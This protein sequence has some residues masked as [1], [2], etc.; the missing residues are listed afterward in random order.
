MVTVESTGKQLSLKDYFALKENASKAFALMNFSEFMSFCQLGQQLCTKS[1]KPV[2]VAN[3]VFFAEIS[4]IAV[5]VYNRWHRR[6]ALGRD[7]IRFKTR[8]HMQLMCGV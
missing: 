8:M 3:A 4:C 2:A 1:S 7:E 6:D 5:D